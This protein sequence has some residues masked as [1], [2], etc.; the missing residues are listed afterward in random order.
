M[1]K[2]S[3]GGRRMK[4]THEI[5]KS[6]EEVV[7]ESEERYRALYE[8]NPSMYFTVDSEG[9]VLS[10]NKFGA[11]QLG[12][13]AEE[14]IG[15]PVLN[16]FYEED[17]EPVQK[18][19]AACL[20][21]PGQTF[22]WEFRKVRK[23]G[24]MLWVREVARAVWDSRGD[25]AVFIVC[26]DITKHKRAEALLK[27][28]EERFRIMS[29][30]APVM[31]WMSGLDKLCT[32]FNKSWLEFTGR[33]MEQEMGNGWAEGVHLED[34]DRCLETYVRCFDAREGFRMEY[35]L[36]RFDGEYRW[37]LDNGTPRFS[38]DGSFAGYIGSCIDITERKQAE[39]VLQKVRAELEVRV[40]ERTRELAKTNETLQAE[41]AERRWA[42]DGLFSDNI[43]IQFLH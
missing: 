42:E 3:V 25:M 41:I 38:A 7:R 5:K 14:L 30:T 12:Y 15:Q 37:I 22:H 33:T 9:R 35:R 29:D 20:H 32:Y 11:E 27:E 36:R 39:E 6:I 31:I 40:E 10:V 13:T 24:S 8:D 43:F 26:E 18:Q 19:V 23:D 21:N 34:F 4:D 16:V 17:K 2:A 28:S 1:H